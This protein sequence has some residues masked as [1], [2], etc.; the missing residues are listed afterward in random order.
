MIEKR[1]VKARKKLE[2]ADVDGILIGKL[3]NIRYLTGFTGSNGL[4]IVGLNDSVFLTD[5]RYIEQAEKEVCGSKIELWEE[6]LYEKLYN[7]LKESGTKNLG[8]ESH[9]FTFRHFENFKDNFR[10]INLKP[11]SNFIENI[12]TIKDED[13]LF[14][15]SKAAEI[16]DKGLNY[17]LPFLKEGVREKDI[18]LELELFLKKNGAE[19]ISFDIIVASGPNSSMPH[20]AAGERK[21]AKGDFVIIDL[22][23]VYQGYHSDMTRT[24]AIEDVSEKQKD[25]YETVLKAQMLALNQVKVGVNCSFVDKTARDFIGER[26]Y[27]RFFG[28]GTGHGVGLEIHES[29][30]ISMSSKDV[31]REGM[32]FTI[33]PG[34]YIPDFGGVRIEDLLV[35]END[36]PKILTK[37]LKELLV[38]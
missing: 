33:E 31:L 5:F 4:L 11:L 23:V 27:S 34:V 17:I 36:G 25:V 21:I 20:A 26:G 15:I 19:K 1:L 18:V 24:A 30:F 7:I 37:T 13:E 12:R 16:V 32:V 8:F 29:P 38:L 9:F 22:G 28:H 6:P 35:L 14:K 3:E 10:E 2:E